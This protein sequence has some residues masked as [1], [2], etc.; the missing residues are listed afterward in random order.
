VSALTREEML[1]RRQEK[2]RQLATFVI[3]D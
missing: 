3:E 1:R 2:L